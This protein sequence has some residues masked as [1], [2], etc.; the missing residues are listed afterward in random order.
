MWISIA[1]HIPDTMSAQYEVT[2]MAGPMGFGVETPADQESGSVVTE[3]AAGS[4]AEKEGVRVN[5]VLVAVGGTDVTHLDHEDAVDLIGS[6]ARPVVLR[7][8][9]VGDETAMETPKDEEV[10]LQTD[11]PTDEE[12]TQQ[13]ETPQDQEATEAVPLTEE[14]EAEKKETAAR[15]AADEAEKKAK[16]EE[17][18][19]KRKEK[20]QKG[21]M[22][23]T[24]SWSRLTGSKWKKKADTSIELK[25]KKAQEEEEKRQL[26]EPRIESAS[27]DAK[28]AEAL[29]K[30]C[31]NDATVSPA[32]AKEANTLSRLAK[33][34][35]ERSQILRVVVCG[36]GQAEPVLLSN[37]SKIEQITIARLANLHKMKKTSGVYRPPT[38]PGD[39][40]DIDPFEEDSDEEHNEMGPIQAILDT[41]FGKYKPEPPLRGPDTNANNF[42]AEDWLYTN[43]EDFSDDDP[44][45]DMGNDKDP[46]YR[47]L[48][49]EDITLKYQSGMETLHKAYSQMPGNDSTQHN[50]GLT[51][52]FESLND[53]KNRLGWV[54]FLRMCKDFNLITRENK[55]LKNSRTGAGYEDIA[56]VEWIAAGDE[57]SVSLTGKLPVL[58]DEAK[59]IFKKVAGKKSQYNFI[60]VP[61][62][63]QVIFAIV[64][65]AWPRLTA[66]IENHEREL[67]ASTA[68]KVF[69]NVCKCPHVF[70]GQFRTLKQDGPNG[71]LMR[72]IRAT[73]SHSTRY[74]FG[75]NDIVVARILQ[76]YKPTEDEMDAFET[77]NIED[78]TMFDEL[79]TGDLV[80]VLAVQNDIGD[81]DN[82]DD[83][84]WEEWLPVPKQKGA[85][86]MV[87][88]KPGQYWL[89]EQ[90]TIDGVPVDDP[91]AHFEH[92]GILPSD[93]VE[94]VEV[95]KEVELSPELAAIRIQKLARGSMLRSRRAR[96]WDASTKIAA[97]VRAQ[98]QRKRYHRA[99]RARQLQAACVVERLLDKQPDFPKLYSILGRLNI[100]TKNA[101]IDSTIAKSRGFV[102]A[103]GN[104]KDKT[105]GNLGRK[106]IRTQ[107]SKDVVRVRKA[108]PKYTGKFA[109][110]KPDRV[111]QDIPQHDPT[112]DACQDLYRYGL[113]T[114]YKAYCATFGVRKLEPDPTFETMGAAQGTINLTGFAQ[115]C[116]D[117]KL[118]QPTF[119]GSKMATLY[120]DKNGDHRFTHEGYMA[121]SRV[122]L[123]AT[124]QRWCVFHQDP[125]D[126]RTAIRSW[127]NLADI[128][129][130]LAWHSYLKLMKTDEDT[131][132]GATRPEVAAAMYTRMSLAEDD[133]KTLHCILMGFGRGMTFAD[134]KLPGI[135]EKYVYQDMKYAT[136]GAKHPIDRMRMAL[137][138]RKSRGVDIR[139]LFTNLDM[140][141]YG[142]EHPSGVLKPENMWKSL[143]I[144]LEHGLITP[145]EWNLE[146]YPYLAERFGTKENAR[147]SGLYEAAEGIDY[148]KFCEWIDE[149]LP[150]FHSDGHGKMLE[151]KRHRHRLMYRSRAQVTKIRRD[152]YGD[153]LG[154]MT[155][156]EIRRIEEEEEKRLRNSVTPPV[157]YDEGDDVIGQQF[158]K[159]SGY[160]EHWDA[161]G[162]GEH[163]NAGVE[164]NHPMGI[165]QPMPMPP[166]GQKMGESPLTKSRTRI[167]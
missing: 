143:G 14:E 42:V 122:E 56:V 106:E 121:F 66:T 161:S 49:M 120:I 19:R 88:K 87:G 77:D 25:K 6:S 84:N 50:K 47:D 46:E 139:A 22:F 79:K 123:K 57:T 125:K 8:Q 89:A 96:I 26:R 53:S 5:D 72:R 167:I 81:E 101:A 39:E 103:Q 127:K 41:S 85:K 20:A 151:Q 145:V 94:I 114:L 82:S 108:P 74:N 166:A 32:V 21:G 126:D 155:E 135:E 142:W 100:D 48:A 148:V 68:L 43:D 99:L 58:R 115:L 70:K 90:L 13:T 128:I 112:M 129:A 119:K 38:A 62:L 45:D 111:R 165:P 1:Q 163:F 149:P 33:D 144:I 17:E 2:F 44:F 159:H 153:A 158:G 15:L 150:D 156:A 59:A 97:M 61:Q 7:F 12:V 16:E 36:A 105:P 133:I 154:K 117:F 63:M 104:F 138:E 110:G 9:K 146:I 162:V 132:K 10:T 37:L 27:H 134:G 141:S 98:Q 91:Y 147:A 160:H 113:E 118:I 95:R 18:E 67:W 78:Q 152:K 130:E 102:F 60:S 136:K 71:R 157:N 11:A 124:Y 30:E 86:C 52:T 80:R 76:D 35:L 93:I 107:A 40:S 51:T 3:V 75:S 34:D 54:P 23:G 83:G 24:L 69:R 116:A 137:H 31:L 4:I 55:L 28:L 164:M 29:I 131:L 92:R 65:K 109:K 140:Q 64:L 73:K